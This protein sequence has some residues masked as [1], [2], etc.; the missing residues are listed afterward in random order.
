MPRLLDGRSFHF[1][2]C[3]EDGCCVECGEALEFDAEFGEDLV[4]L[5]QAECCNLRYVLKPTM[6]VVEHWETGDEG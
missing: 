3:I 5:V 6:V 1:D 4:A 2:D